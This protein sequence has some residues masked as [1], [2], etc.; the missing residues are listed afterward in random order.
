MLLLL[1]WISHNNQ[2]RHGLQS[3]KANH[4]VSPQFASN[5]KKPVLTPKYVLVSEMRKNNKLEDRM[6]HLEKQ[7]EMIQSHL[8]RL[9][10]SN[11]NTQKDMKFFETMLLEEYHLLLQLLGK[12]QDIR[13]HQADHS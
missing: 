5:A 2:N 8:H 7:L 12:D 1:I 3:K 13:I 9:T 11:E 6:E 4:K 10:K